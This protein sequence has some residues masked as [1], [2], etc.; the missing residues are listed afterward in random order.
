MDLLSQLVGASTCKQQSDEIDQEIDLASLATAT[1]CLDKGEGLK[2][3]ETNMNITK[4][5]VT[6]KT[7]EPNSENSDSFKFGIVESFMLKVF[8]FTPFNLL[9]S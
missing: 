5:N 1:T 8:L 9:K 6:C 3:M 2:M 7:E 4:P